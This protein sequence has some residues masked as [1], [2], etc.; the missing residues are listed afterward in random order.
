M[1][2]ASVSTATPVAYARTTEHGC[3]VVGHD[4]CEVDY[5]ESGGRRWGELHRRTGVR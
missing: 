4:V 5:G 2:S 3:I 1:S